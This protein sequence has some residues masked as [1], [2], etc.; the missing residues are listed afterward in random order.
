MKLKIG[1]KQE[2][3]LLVLKVQH[4]NEDVQKLRSEQVKLLRDRKRLRWLLKN[5]GFVHT[6]YNGF[7]DNMSSRDIDQLMKEEGK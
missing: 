7:V 6:Y 2:L 4:L 5:L 3:A 1:Q